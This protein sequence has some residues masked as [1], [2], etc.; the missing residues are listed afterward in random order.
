MYF[1]IFSD[2]FGFINGYSLVLFS[3]VI[4]LKLKKKYI[5]YKYRIVVNSIYR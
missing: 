1:L 5:Y 2:F 4:L 3:I